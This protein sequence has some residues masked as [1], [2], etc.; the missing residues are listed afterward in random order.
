MIEKNTIP[1]AQ[2]Y[3]GQ[4]TPTENWI[5]GTL[6]GFVPTFQFDLAN[7]PLDDT[8]SG[9]NSNRISPS[10]MVLAGLRMDNYLPRNDSGIIRFSRRLPNGGKQELFTYTTE[11][12][13]ENADWTQY[14]SFDYAFIGNFSWEINDQPGQYE[15]YMK[16]PQGEVVIGFE[17]VK[18][19]GIPV[20]GEAPPMFQPPGTG[21]RVTAVFGTLGSGSVQVNGTTRSS[22]EVPAGSQLEL[23][24]VPSPGWKFLYWFFGDADIGSGITA[25]PL[26]QVF[27]LPGKIS[28]KFEKREP[29][30][31]KPIGPGLPNAP[32]TVPPVVPCIAGPRYNASAWE[33]FFGCSKKGYT[34]VAADVLEISDGYCV[35]ESAATQPGVTPGAPSEGFGLQDTL[36]LLPT[37]L[38]VTVIASIIGAFRR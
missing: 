28:A 27:G 10:E 22:M 32:E 35:C 33:R 12:F 21:N 34:W 18:T 17:V 5:R 11:D 13:P 37:L 38:I 9:G 14:H 7:F 16:Y 26:K 19:G 6:P 2:I 3:F 15:V 25:N 24:A 30:Y 8:P 31:Q 4:V 36:K 23:K 20:P 1:N 29:I